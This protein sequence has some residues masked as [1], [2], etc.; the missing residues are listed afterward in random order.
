MAEIE[1]KPKKENRKETEGRRGV[2]L[3]KKGGG[4]EGSVVREGGG[5]RGEGRQNEAE[6]PRHQTQIN[7]VVSSPLADSGNTWCEAL[8]AAAWMIEVVETKVEDELLL[9]REKERER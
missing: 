7:L 9:E 5:R 2:Y 1:G 4:G 6:I 3:R 8:P